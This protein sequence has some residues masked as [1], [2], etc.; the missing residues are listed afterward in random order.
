[1]ESSTDANPM[2]YDFLDMLL[3]ESPNGH[4]GASSPSNSSLNLNVSGNAGYE[5]LNPMHFQPT[6]QQQPQQHHQ[7]PPQQLASQHNQLH[8]VKP[9]A[10]T[11][12]SSHQY[13]IQGM[14]YISNFPSHIQRLAEE[15]PKSSPTKNSTCPRNHLSPWIFQYKTLIFFSRFSKFHLPSHCPHGILLRAV[16]LVSPTIE[17]EGD[18]MSHYVACYHDN[19]ISSLGCAAHHKLHARP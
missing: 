5:M 4:T 15:T 17:D 10:N 18:E 19:L 13:P 1:M 6:T 2:G 7:Q 14:S 12:S 3:Q 9:S 16:T 8:L 11:G